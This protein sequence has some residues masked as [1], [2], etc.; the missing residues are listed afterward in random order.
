MER[1]K[2]L[3]PI[4][5]LLFLPTEAH[6]CWNDDEEDYGNYD[7]SVDDYLDGY[8]VVITPDDYDYYY[9]DDDYDY[10]I[11]NY[12][13]GFEVVITPD[14]DDE[15]DSSQE[16]FLWHNETEEDDN[17]DEDPMGWKDD[18]EG[19]TVGKKETTTGKTK[20]TLRQYVIKAKDKTVIEETIQIS[21]KKQK[22]KMSCVPTAMEYAAIIK[23]NP[24]YETKYRNEFINDY[25]LIRQNG[26]AKNEGVYK[27]DIEAF[28]KYEFECNDIATMTSFINAIDNGN[29]ILCT[30]ESNSGDAFSL[31]E[32]EITIIGYTEDKNRFILI[33]PA[34]GNYKTISFWEL[35]TPSF[36]I[37][38]KKKKTL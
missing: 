22:E 32:H 8:D 26:D 36:E 15:G 13:N 21:W 38:S 25:P 29:P 16:Y 37:K 28:I 3:L 5:L 11:D 24:T 35:D 10:S 18:D 9:D 6:A 23:E 4:A 33:D 14:S 2:L 34:D 30:I 20:P 17:Y 1:L 27:Q 31:M 12:M 7:L 19:S